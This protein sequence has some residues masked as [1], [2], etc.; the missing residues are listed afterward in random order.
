M[1]EIARGRRRS[2]LLGSFN[3]TFQIIV[4]IC[5]GGLL[6]YFIEGLLSVTI[7]GLETFWEF[8]AAAA[9]IAGLIF[10]V[11]VFQYERIKRQ[12]TATAT[13]VDASEVDDRTCLICGYSPE[14][15]W[16]GELVG[17]MISDLST[18]PQDLAAA[19]RRD[20]PLAKQVLGRWQQNLRVLNAFPKVKRLYVLMPNVDQFDRFVEVLRHFYPTN[21]DLEITQVTDKHGNTAFRQG[22]KKMLKPD[23]EDF[24]YVTHGIGLAIGNI[25]ADLDLSQG[26]AERQTIIDVTGGLKTFSIVGAIASLNRDLIFAYAGTNDREGEVLVYDAEVQFF[27]DLRL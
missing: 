1:K 23:Y 6:F 21:E 10:L 19:C 22:A 12:V 20:N 27:D 2:K 8:V 15:N 4:A 11:V 7:T 26:E 16:K 9:I 24:D 25:K 18:L 3:L 13:V 5:L 14:V 17:A